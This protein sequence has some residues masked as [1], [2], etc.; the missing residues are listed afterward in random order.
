VHFPGLEGEAEE[1]D[2]GAIT[3]QQR[4][5]EES[6]WYG[7]LDGA[8]LHIGY[9]RISRAMRNSCAS[10]YVWFTCDEMHSL[11]RIAAFSG[12]ISM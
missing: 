11:V 10:A 4:R 3:H 12:Q 8:P 2:K 1:R 9:T 7:S 6:T 5:E